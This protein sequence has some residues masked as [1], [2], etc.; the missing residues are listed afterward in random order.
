MPMGADLAVLPRILLVDDEADIRWTVGELLKDEGFDVV[1][2]RSADEAL[3][4]IDE[5]GIPHL[6]VVDIMMPEVDGI[7]LCRRL[8]EFSDVPVI[9][10]TAVDDQETITGAIREFADDYVVKPF[11]PDELA[12]RIRRVLGRFKTF[13]YATGPRLVIDDRLAL[14]LAAGRAMVDG[15]A[16]ELTPTETRLL[17][18]LTRNAGRLVSTSHLLQR[19]WPRKE[20]YEDSLRVHVHR[21]RH[22]IEVD[23]SSPR[24]LTNERGVGYRFSI[25]ENPD[26]GDPAS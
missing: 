22:K 10:L 6:A 26:G 23:P 9:M 1:T 12:A 13:D 3:R 16:V 17:H 4:R 5:L 24:Y 25:P 14:E 15:E 18:V 7:D 19:V 8:R 2:A 21:I 20:V 11:D